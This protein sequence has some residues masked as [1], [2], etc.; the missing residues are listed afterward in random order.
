MATNTLGENINQAVSDFGAIKDAI[1]L[2]GIDIPT[3]T[4]TSEYDTKIGEMPPTPNYGFVV[5]AFD[6]GGYPTAGTFYGTE[7]P[8]YYF[9]QQREPNCDSYLKRV[10]Q[11]NFADE[12]ISIGNQSFRMWTNNQKSI[13]NSVKYIGEGGFYENNNI[14]W[15]ALPSGLI[16]IGKEA[17]YNCYYLA[18]T[19]MPST[20]TTIGYRAFYFCGYIRSLTF[21]G[22]PTTIDS[23]AFYGCQYCY[24]L[25]VPWAQGAVAGAPWGMGNATITYDYTQ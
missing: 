9:F 17:F 13:P 19:S 12:L 8:P 15:T 16:T 6:S 11:M 5:N 4:P 25:N 22:T 18:I 24:T 20:V 10:T 1:V 14:P 2:K 7:I 23:T 3:G 21:L